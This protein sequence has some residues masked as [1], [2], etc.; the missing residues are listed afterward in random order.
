MMEK[1]III[2]GG[3]AGLTCGIALRSK[4]ID[5]DIYE[6]AESFEPISFE[7]MRTNTEKSTYFT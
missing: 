7:A 4:S 1:G 6:S 5:A 3:I 2:G